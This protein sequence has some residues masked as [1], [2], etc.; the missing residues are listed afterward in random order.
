MRKIIYRKHWYI[1]LDNILVVLLIVAVLAF[2]VWW[3]IYRWN[4]CRAVG[5][6]KL[7]CIMTAGK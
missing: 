7:Y 6:T 4:D 2:A 1:R 5:H 3:Q